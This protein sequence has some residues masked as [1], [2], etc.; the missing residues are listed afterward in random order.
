MRRFMLDRL[1]PGRTLLNRRRAYF[2]EASL[3]KLSHQARSLP[4]S[5]GLGFSSLPRGPG[6]GL[7]PSMAPFAE[8]D[9][10]SAAVFFFGSSFRSV[11]PQSV[12]QM[13]YKLSPAGTL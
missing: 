12:L 10:P 2:L 9:G 7:S 5:S 1:E 8:P 13:K 3:S 6:N 11:T 4:G